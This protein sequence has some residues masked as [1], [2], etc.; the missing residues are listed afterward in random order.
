MSQTVIVVKNAEGDPD[1]KATILIKN[2]IDYIPKVSVIIPVYN[3]EK[4]LRECLDSVIN[5]SL[6]EIEIICVDDG[7]TDNSLEILKEYAA[8]DN[9]I[10]VLAQENLYAGVARN[11]GMMV[12]SGEYYHFLDSDDCMSGELNYFYNEAC[13]NQV[14]LFKFKNIIYDD[15]N[16]LYYQNDYILI[17]K[18]DKKYF[19]KLIKNPKIDLLLNLPDSAWS[20]I[21]KASFIEKFDIKFDNLKCVNDVSFFIKC[22]N[23][24]NS[25]YISNKELI[26][27]RRNHVNSLMQL[28]ADNLVDLIRQFK[29]IEKVDLKHK[30]IILKY[31]FMKIKSQFI[32]NLDKL[33]E[34]VFDELKTISYR[35][36]NDRDLINFNDFVIAYKPQQ[37]KFNNFY[38]SYPKILSNDKGNG[39]SIEGSGDCVIYLKAIESGLFNITFRSILSNGFYKATRYNLIKI[40]DEI[41]SILPVITTDNSPYRYKLKVKNGDIL[42]LE[43]RLG[44]TNVKQDFKVNIRNVKNKKNSVELVKIKGI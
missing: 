32:N 14:E 15:Y 18:L 29:N 8:K 3:T 17:S 1:T 20:G 22:I 6:K 36:F 39:I 38:Y 13:K 41:I 12:A 16:D 30:Q 19:N 23:N 40:N 25:L 27:Y 35:C 31:I 11:A 44:I 10:T 9:R 43:F 34:D 4:Y 28:R 37:T 33:S 7:S 42:K 21:Y 2:K 24:L 5:Q 26:I